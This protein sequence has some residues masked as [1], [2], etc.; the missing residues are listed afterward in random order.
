MNTSKNVLQ[1]LCFRSP[2]GGSFF[3][4]LL[5]LE[6][7]LKNDHTDMVYLFHVDTSDIDWVQDLIKEGRNIYFLSGSFSKDI[8]VVKNILVKHNIKY[9]HAHF[10]GAKYF[11]L[12]NIVKY[13]Y[14]N[15]LLIIRH[16]RNHDQP[17]GAVTETLRKI[18][19]HVDLYIG[20]SESVAIE[21][22]KNFKLNGKNVT[23]ATNAI[24]FKRLDQYELLQRSEFNIKPNT[25]VFLMFGFD[26]LRKGVDVV[27]DAMN[28]LVEQGYD[29]C[30]L[31]SLSVNKESIETKI[32]ERFQEIPE[33]LRIM[34][35][36]D[37]IASYYQLSNYFISASREE[38]FCNALVES[39]Y[40]ERPIITSDIPGPKSLCI[41][42]TLKFQ[43]EN[44][45]ELQDAM[46][47]LI[48]LTNDQ[49]EKIKSEQKEYVVKNF[50]LDQW[51]NKISGIYKDLGKADHTFK[52]A[53][54]GQMF[55]T[56]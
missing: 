54:D 46:I 40:C 49:K 51:A 1:F 48:S 37:D 12:F 53:M 7:T 35:P 33:W 31:L 42:H 10:A 13:L 29:V 50:D 6:Q 24:D 34:K 28:K 11:L 52:D 19:N 21:Y 43:S 30:L 16:L 17:R 22:Q 5:R 3:K 39:A 32:K 8:F 36:R 18:L 27:L 41:P 45:T 14:G 23:F 25:I 4:S 56:A 20:C 26:Y 44:I 38:G 47:S 55:E 15:K 2:Y 9:I